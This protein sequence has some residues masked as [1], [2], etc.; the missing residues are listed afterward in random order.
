MPPSKYDLHVATCLRMNW[1]CVECGQVVQKSQREQH[2]K[3]AHAVVFCEC[4]EELDRSKLASHKQNDCPKRIVKCN[5]CPLD[6]PYVEIWAHE[7]TCGAKTQKCFFCNEW[8]KNKD[9]DA[10]IEYCKKRKEGT[11]TEEDKPPVVAVSPTRPVFGDYISCP[12]CADPFQEWD[13]LQIHILCNHP[14]EAENLGTTGEPM[15]NEKVTEN[16]DQQASN[17][18]APES[19]SNS[20]ANE[21]MDTNQN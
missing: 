21:N 14:S 19:N 17:N 5:Y 12:Y 7:Q 10:H 13:D 16:V 15:K 18:A 1:Y 20:N 6:M 11:L 2:I 9:W 8:I 4:G 3:E